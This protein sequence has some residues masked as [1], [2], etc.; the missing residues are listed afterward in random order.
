MAG[1]EGIGIPW[2][3]HSSVPERGSEGRLGRWTAGIL[4]FSVFRAPASLEQVRLQ[5]IKRN[6]TI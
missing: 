3:L 6:K 4:Q 1:G 5:Q 2:C